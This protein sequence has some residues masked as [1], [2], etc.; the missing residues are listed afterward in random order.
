[1]Y[2]QL[3]WIVEPSKPLNKDGLVDLS[4]SKFL[5]INQICQNLQSL[6]PNVHP[7]IDQLLLSLTLHRKTGTRDVVDTIH[8]LGYGVPYTEVLF[9]ENKWAEWTIKQEHHIPS[10]IKRGVYTTHI[11]DNIGWARTQIHHTN[12][13]LIQHNT[14]NNE[15][16]FNSMHMEADYNFD[17]RNS[18]S[19]NREKGIS[20]KQIQTSTLH[21]TKLPGKYGKFRNNGFFKKDSL[22]GINTHEHK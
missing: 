15:R 1:M 2:N 19:F 11:A 13:I 21:T 14:K 10:N 18:R 16:E 17:R 3:A 7:S 20:T 12:S 5:K 6:L 22:L 8:K 4:H 9:V